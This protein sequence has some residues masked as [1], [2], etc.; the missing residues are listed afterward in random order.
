MGLLKEMEIVTLRSYIIILI[1]LWKHHLNIYRLKQI[2][3]NGA[4]VYSN[5]V[6][7]N[8]GSSQNFALAQNYPNPFNPSTIIKY[9]IPIEGLVTQ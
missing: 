9:H 4:F 5:E 3:V 6:E 8:L 7:A 2:D 1:N